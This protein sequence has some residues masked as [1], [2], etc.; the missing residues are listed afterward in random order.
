M[1]SRTN[2]RTIHSGV[3]DDG[4]LYGRGAIDDKGMLAANVMD[5]LVISRDMAARG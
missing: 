1:W 2:G 3:V 5:M 4:Y